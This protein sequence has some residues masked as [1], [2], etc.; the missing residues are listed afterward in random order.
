MKDPDFPVVSIVVG[1]VD[2][3]IQSGQA[4]GRLL[5]SQGQYVTVVRVVTVIVDSDTPCDA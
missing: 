3:E 2:R 4:V 5:V 1:F